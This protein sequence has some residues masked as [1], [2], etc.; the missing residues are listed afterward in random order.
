MGESG[1]EQRPP[2]GRPKPQAESAAVTGAAGSIRYLVERALEGGVRASL[3]HQAKL[4]RLAR[5]RPAERA[6]I[7][8]YAVEEPA[9]AAIAGEGVGERFVGAAESDR[10]RQPGLSLRTRAC[11]RGRLGT[12]RIILEERQE[13]HRAPIVLQ[14]SA[15]GTG[16]GSR[17]GGGRLRLIDMRSTAR[18]ALQVVGALFGVLAV[19]FALGAWRLSSGPLSL[20]FLSPYIQEA[21]EGDDLAYHFEFEDTVLVWAGWGQALEIQLT[22]LRIADTGGATLA[23]V[24]A[25]SLGLSGAALLRGAIA[26]TSIELIEPRLGL[27]RR[28]D[29]SV[30]LAGSGE[31]V[32]TDAAAGDALVADLLDP[33]REDHPLSQLR[34]VSLR[35]AAIVLSDEVA[36]LTW[37]APNA[38]LTLN[39]DDAAILGH[40]SMALQVKELE[41]HVEVELFHHRESKMGSAAIGFTGLNLAELAFIA[42]ELEEFE[43][44]RVPLSGTLAFDVA[45][46]GILGGVVFDI[47]GGEGEIALP[48]VFASPVPIRRLDAA[49]SIDGELSRLILEAFVIDTD[50]PQ[51]SL[52]GEL[53]RTDAGVGIKGRFQAS[54]MPF[55]SLV[56]YWPDTFI[57]SGRE[58]IVENIADGVI[59]RFEAALDIAPG[60]FEAERFSAASAAGSFAFEDASIHYLRPMPP[61]AGVDGTAHFTGDTLDIAMSGGRIDGISAPHGTA[62]LSDIHTAKPRMSVMVE[63]EGPMADALALLD[64]PRDS[65]WRARWTGAWRR[66]AVRCTPSSR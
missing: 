59:T 21:L 16:K 14:G 27:V 42:P 38:D 63:A 13:R 11:A 35:D 30:H 26:P 55:D 66:P 56:T 33:P 48:E 18:I 4:G 7:A 6:A 9:G 15:Q 29:G 41:T 5:Q 52:E 44:L 24:P 28:P 20:G 39:L 65:G 34:R 50:R 54:D 25:A 10:C 64:H 53:W 23:A 60:D 3:G 40:L 1:G 31:G 43:G 17:G 58:W 32:S 22:D 61:V 19:L 36:D 57:A 2:L 49:G 47:A 45:P 46:G 62:S 12:D 37:T 51:F 8:E